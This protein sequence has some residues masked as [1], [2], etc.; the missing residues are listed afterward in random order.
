MSDDAGH[1]GEARNNQRLKLPAMYTLLR[2]R[3]V[4]DKRYRWTGHIYDISS[5]GTRSIP[6]RASSNLISKS[7]ECLQSR[8]II[9]DSVNAKESI[10]SKISLHVE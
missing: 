6:S 8:V 10:D 4:G 5:T 9:A 7:D 1:A 2:V 3:H